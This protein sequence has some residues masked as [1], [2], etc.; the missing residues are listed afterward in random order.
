M[1]VFLMRI[2]FYRTAIILF[3]ISKSG[4]TVFT[5][6]LRPHCGRNSRDAVLTSYSDS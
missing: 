5:I 3:G 1:R 4:R 2:F 6:Q